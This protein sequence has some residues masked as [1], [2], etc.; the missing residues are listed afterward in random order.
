MKNKFTLKKILTSAALIIL[1]AATV[2]CG[3]YKPSNND[4]N[5]NGT[6]QEQT[7]NIYNYK[8]GVY[9]LISNGNGTYKAVNYFAVLNSFN[10]DGKTDDSQNLQAL[11]DKAAKTVGVNFIGGFSALV[12]KGCTK[13]DK[14]LIATIPEAMATTERVCS[15]VN[16]ATSKAGINMDAVLKMSEMIKNAAE[17]TKEQDGIGA[18]KIVVFL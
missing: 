11:L 7:P 15:S 14:L 9:S 4:P 3:Q 8:D 17:L 16:L 2:S 6:V 12:E 5:N 13:G 10:A 1:S 18:A